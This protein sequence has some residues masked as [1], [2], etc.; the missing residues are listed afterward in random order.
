M[1][2]LTIFRGHCKGMEVKHFEVRT[3]KNFHIPAGSCGCY[4]GA[5]AELPRIEWNNAEERAE[6]IQPEGNHFRC[7]FHPFGKYTNFADTVGAVGASPCQKYLVASGGRLEVFFSMVTGISRELEELYLRRILDSYEGG[8]AVPDGV[9]TRLVQ[10]RPEL[11]F[12]GADFSTLKRILRYDCRPDRANLVCEEIRRKR[13]TG[14]SPIIFQSRSLEFKSEGGTQ[15][16]ISYFKKR[17]DIVANLNNMTTIESDDNEIGHHFTID[18][19]QFLLKCSIEI[20]LLI[21]SEVN[22]SS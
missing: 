18:C 4:S 3:T 20:R 9:L 11:H 8:P 14:N 2:Q 7:P 15:A 17:E 12:T 21:E 6:I 19:M 16:N 5:A 1:A 10:F 22:A 13:V